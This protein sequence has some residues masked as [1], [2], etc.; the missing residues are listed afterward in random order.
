MRFL[1]AT[2]L[3][4]NSMIAIIAL[5]IL[6][7]ASYLDHVI[8]DRTASALQSK[9]QQQLSQYHNNLVTNLQNHIQIVRGLPG[10][11]AVNPELTQAQFEIAMSHLI[12][13]HT[14]LRN[15]AAAPDMVIRYMYP[16]AGNEQA[17]GLDYRQE[18]SQADAAERARVTRKLILAGPLELKQGGTG[19]ITR[20]PVYLLDES[21][22]EY[23]WGII[24]AVIDAE[25]FF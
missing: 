7:A 19:L 11:F 23:F 15:I 6:V 22:Q 10:L 21:G 18:P 17:I 1:I 20:I 2:K 3:V 8:Q 25:T 13:K 14:Q 5:L 9:V 4:F 16:V 24:S 12:G